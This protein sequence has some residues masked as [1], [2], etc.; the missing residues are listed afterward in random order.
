MCHYMLVWRPDGHAPTEDVPF[1]RDSGTNPS[2]FEISCDHAGPLHMPNGRLRRGKHLTRASRGSL[3]HDSQM[4]DSIRFVVLARVSK[5]IKFG[6]PR[7]AEKFF[8]NKFEI[9][10]TF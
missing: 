6:D 7:L 8:G 4:D 3:L 9:A 10:T 5:D 2:D 1:V